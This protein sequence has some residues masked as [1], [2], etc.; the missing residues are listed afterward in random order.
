MQVKG[1]NSRS[2][3]SL[4]SLWCVSSLGIAQTRPDLNT[5]CLEQRGNVMQL[6]MDGKPFLILGG[7]CTA[8]GVA[9]QAAREAR[10]GH[11]SQLLRDLIDEA[12]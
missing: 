5:P 3:L 7:S 11:V 6:I 2:A 9:M 12:G 4:L 1:G 10:L 8:F